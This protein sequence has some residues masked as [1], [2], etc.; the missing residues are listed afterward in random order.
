MAN[1]LVNGINLYYEEVGHGV[2][3]VFVH[4]FA[5]EIASW[6]PQIGFSAG[7]TAQLRSMP[8]AILLPMYRMIFHCIPRHRR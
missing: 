5:G 4:E 7:A 6:R 2:P 8:A 1:A 3:M